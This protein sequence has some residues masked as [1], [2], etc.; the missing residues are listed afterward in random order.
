MAVVYIREIYKGVSLEVGTS[1]RTTTGSVNRKFLVRVDNFSTGG[2]RICG[3]IGV[4]YGS[5]HPALTGW[6]ATKFRV[7]CEDGA[8]LLW[9]VNVTYEP[10]Q[11][12]EPSG[13]KAGLPPDEWS[14]ATSVAMWPVAFYLR[15][16]TVTDAADIK[17][18]VNS[19]GSQIEGLKAEVTEFTWR[20]VRSYATYSE[21]NAIITAATGRIN[22]ATWGGNAKRCWKCDFK[23]ASKKKIQSP[24]QT[25]AGNPASENQGADGEIEEKEYW[26]ATFEFRLDVRTWDL[27]PWDAGFMQKVDDAGKP[28]ETGTKL[29]AITGKD[30]KPVKEPAMLNGKGIAQPAGSTPVALEFWIYR[31]A[32]FSALFGTPPA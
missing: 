24:K 28:S 15:T 23:G 27:K 8:G 31:E 22:G 21:L 5:Q 29:S 3:A 1:G 20:L 6:Y 2:Q 25:N 30:G 32:D 19:A 11:P 16:P 17:A 26:E 18:M 4:R 13:P 7:D 10:T 12:P 9:G 14:I